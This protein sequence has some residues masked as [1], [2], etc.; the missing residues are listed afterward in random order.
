M[1]LLSTKNIPQTLVLILCVFLPWHAFLKT[2]GTSIIPSASILL[3][4][5]KEGILGL[6]M[7]WQITEYIK[8]PTAIIWTRTH[9]LLALFFSWI[10]FQSFFTDISWLNVF[11]GMKYSLSFLG[12]YFFFSLLPLKNLNKKLIVQTLLYSTGASLLFFL[13]LYF[14]FPK[15]ILT[16]FGY[17]SDIATFSA[18]QALSVYQTVGNNIPRFAAGLSGPNQLGFFLIFTLPLL[19]KQNIFIK[20]YILPVFLIALFFTFSRTAWISLI[21]INIIW[22][23]DFFIHHWK[24]I[25]ITS[26]ISLSLL[27][28][29][30]PAFILRPDSSLPRI[31]KAKSSLQYIIQKPLGYG[32]GTFGPAAVRDEKLF[33]V[34]TQKTDITSLKG[35][36]KITKNHIWFESE[37]EILRF[38]PMNIFELKDI[39][40]LQKLPIKTQTAIIH[41]YK[42]DSIDRIS[43]NWHLQMLLEFGIIGG[44]IYLAI[45]YTIYISFY[46]KKTWLHQALFL[47]FIGF[48]CA[49]NF[50]HVFEDSSTS[51]L[52]FFF[53]SQNVK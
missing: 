18:H 40:S 33:Y 45:L 52:F 48:I 30:F 2:W 53:L 20:K 14:F 35:I 13:T 5:W 22:N 10:I 36:P 28:L 29:M 41:L 49:G 34:W 38:K 43:E 8:R 24:K 50:L 12:V 25:S 15:D 42:R 51:L 7:I 16:S 37:K 1:N 39:P 26:I 19:I 21:I 6:L 27:I 46:Q 17:R 11:W 32:L 44:V 3:S 31:E 4:L 9:S 47:S 23:K